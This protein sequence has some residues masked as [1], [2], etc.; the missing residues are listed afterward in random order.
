MM[1][2][3]LVRFTFAAAIV[4]VLVLIV[5]KVSNNNQEKT[6]IDLYVMS[7]CPYSVLAENSF[8]I[9]KDIFGDQINVE[10]NYIVEIEGSTFVSMHGSSEIEE[11]MRQ[12]VIAAYYREKF[13]DYLDVRNSLIQSD[14][15][16]GSLLLVGLDPQ[17][18]KKKV[19]S[20][21]KALLLKSIKKTDSLSIIASPT[22]YI[23]DKLYEGKNDAVSL[24]IA[25]GKE[26]GIAKP[27]VCKKLPECF[28]D[29]DCIQPFKNGRCVNTE[30]LK[31][32]CEFNDAVKFKAYLIESE[33]CL[34]CSDYTFA[35]GTF[36]KMFRGM[37]LKRLDYKTD[38]GKKI[39]K[40]AGLTKLPAIVFDKGIEAAM[41]YNRASAS[42]M[43]K[44]SDMSDYYL[45]SSLLLK[46]RLFLDKE[47][48]ENT[49]T[50]F[51]MSY[52]PFSVSLENALID[53]IK[54]DNLDIELE[55]KYIF[56]KDK[57]NNIVSLHGKD[58]MHEDIEQMIVQKYYPE[59]FFDYI[60]CRNKDI[61]NRD[62]W[63]ECAIS[64][65]LDPKDIEVKAFEESKA[66]V[67]ES[68]RLCRELGITASPTIFWQNNYSLSDRSEL[69]KIKGLE[70][71]SFDGNTGSCK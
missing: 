13:W 16:Q 21:G 30:D 36:E 52:C 55:F 70:K 27:P 33:D 34:D 53:K 4:F 24:A 11:D 65:G 9:L 50:L 64:L 40:E 31:G 66:L 42:G 63:R 19:D 71:L 35:L 56:S 26:L 62:S 58:E 20:V 46:G 5:I 28:S 23:N 29:S 3:I 38:L 41:N 32:F 45:A 59:K 22:I 67:E 69:R 44:K 25:I 8:R 1:K 15:W 61:K 47:I 48:K 2:R 57:E 7:Y 17:D 68:E 37:L 51:V 54:K 6:K 39:S 60:L 12:L 49:I 43:I 14:N 10:I 18:I